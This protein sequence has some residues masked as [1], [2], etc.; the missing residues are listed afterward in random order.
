[1]LQ[2]CGHSAHTAGWRPLRFG[3]GKNVG[4]K[5]QLLSLSR[6]S[7]F[8]ALVDDSA[9]SLSPSQVHAAKGVAAARDRRV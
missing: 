7:G 2:P 1:V 5:Q 3:V 6:T 8:A 9:L 4:R